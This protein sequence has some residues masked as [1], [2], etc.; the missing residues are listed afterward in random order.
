MTNSSGN[1]IAILGAGPIS[2][3]AALYA[4]Y[5]GYQANVYELDR[6]AANVLRWGHVRMFSPFALNC[7]TLGLAALSAQD[8]SYRAPD[9]DELSTGREW[10][11][12]YLIPLSQT[13]LLADSIHENTTVI[14]VGREHVLKGDLIGGRK[15]A[16][17]PFR[18]ILRDKNGERA[19]SADI[20]IDAT[21]V[22]NNPNW[23]GR[24]GLPALGEQTARTHIEHQLPDILGTQRRN[25]EGR[26]TLVVGSGYSAATAVV[27]LASLAESARQT[28]CTWVT[29]S[30]NGSDGAGPIRRIPHDRLPERDSLARAANALAATNDGAITHWP[31]TTIEAIVH[32]ANTQT[33][34]VRLA[35]H[36]AGEHQFD[37]V[38]AN[39]G[40]RPDAR[41]YEELQV[42][43][44]YATGGPMKLAAALVGQ[45]SADCLD[46]TSHGPETLRNP[47]PNFFILG[48]KSYGRNSNFLFSI[49]LQQ[50]RD[51]FTIIAGRDTL[52]L[53][54]SLKNLAS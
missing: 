2:L 9:D 24:G 15:R 26:R 1:R 34:T 27:A 8:P 20:V 19:E 44:C 23:S 38:I 37:R 12:R 5:L 54:A 25:Y 49:G 6:V 33:F 50:I 16:T 47:E 30:A 45:S 39:V 43:Q 29:R 17:V 18:L 13:D 53:Y 14:A 22:F 28:R 4:R 11:D 42:H 36:H 52:D 51:L 3:E 48:A 41:I 40:Y 31:D 46:Q 7:S 10:A 32:D 21:G 35:G